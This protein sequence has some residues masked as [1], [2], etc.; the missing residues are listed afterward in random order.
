MAYS[1]TFLANNSNDSEREGKTR[2]L[3]VHGLTRNRFDFDEFV[4]RAKS[5][6]EVA[7]SSR[8]SIACVDI[9]GRGD[10]DYLSH[11]GHYNLATYTLAL[12]ALNSSVNKIDWI[13][14][15]MGGLL[16]M[17]SAGAKGSP[18]RSLV[19]NDIGPFVDAAGVARLLEYVGKEG[20]WASMDDVG[21]HFRRI[22]APYGALSDGQWRALSEAS[23]QRREG[24]YVRRY[25]AAIGAGVRGESADLDMFDVWRQIKCPVLLLRGADSDILS[26]QTVER[27]HATRH[28]DA[29]PLEVFTVAGVGHAPSLYEADQIDRIVDFLHSVEQAK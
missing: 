1:E 16:G 23:V 17:V 9:V 7:D 29:P 8:Q 25:D 28:P 27:M 4:A 19:L 21:S 24:A 6:L 14:T 10:S 12:A 5:K 2:V 22:Y 18:V 11:S 26:T 3:C 15:S 13:G 20:P